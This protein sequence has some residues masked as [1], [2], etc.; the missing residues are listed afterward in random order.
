MPT[1]S[2]RL[3][4]MPACEPQPAIPPDARLLTVEQLCGL[5]QIDRRTCERWSSAG[6]LPGKI[7]IGRTVRY[8]RHALERFIKERQQGGQG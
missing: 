4:S 2:A 6:L 3:L 7:R 5:L 1:N 8:D